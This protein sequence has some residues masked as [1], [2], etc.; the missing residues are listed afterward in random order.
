MK[1][2]LF[3]QL[4]LTFLA[5]III[6]GGIITYISIDTA[7]NYY[8]ESNQ[9]L[10]ANVAD[11]LVK[12]VKTFDENNQIDTNGIADIMHSMMVINPD[13]EVYLLD[14]EGE[15]LTHVAPYKKVVRERVNTKPI[16]DFIKSEGSLYVVGDDPR[17]KKGQ[18]TFSAAPILKNEKL[19]GYCYIILASEE[20]ATVFNAHNSSL[21]MKL[22]CQFMIV[23]LLGSIILGLLAFWL[24][25]KNM[26]AI[27]STVEEY[28]KGNYK[29][30]VKPLGNS[31]FSIIGSTLNKMS[32][33][34]EQNIQKMKSIDTFRKE[35]IANI[36]HD[37]RTP[38]AIIKGFTETLIL[39]KDSITPDDRLKYLENIDESSKRL[40]GLVNQLFE[41]SKLENNQVKVNKEPFH[42]DELTQD[43]LDGFQVLATNKNISL[44][45]KRQ[46]NLPL[47]F[48]DIS[49]VE[50]V[51]Q[52]LVDNALKFTPQNGTVEIELSSKGKSDI[53]FNITDNG[54][55][56]DESNISQIFERYS[57]ARKD[58]QSMKGAGLGLAIANKI[59]E[60]HNSKIGVKSKL[61]EGTSFYFNVPVYTQLA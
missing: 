37:L 43:L 59:M 38:L 32:T 46:D 52:N 41:L 1:N 20:R 24:Q 15:I 40:S 36:S 56:I 6:L 27:I 21:A 60:L 49:L 50:R 3:I 7:Q 55:G 16:K 19:L 44:Q 2:K 11:F 14:Q 47:A 18:K 17:N 39:K 25:T 26:A 4:A 22:G 57:S 13:V 9:K 12:H 30:K 29:A 53:F 51:I 45:L 33:S 58:S 28:E 48:G 31:N 10:N 35:L 8:Q 23:A 5:L 34:I 61:K 42:I 54:Q